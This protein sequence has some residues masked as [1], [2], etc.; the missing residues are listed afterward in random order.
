MNNQSVSVPVSRASLQAGCWVSEAMGLSQLQPELM[1]PAAGC[2]PALSQR[3][4]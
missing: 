1:G 4:D 3:L 2:S